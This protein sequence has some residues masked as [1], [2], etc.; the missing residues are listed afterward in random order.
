L[1]ADV[2]KLAEVGKPQREVYPFRDELQRLRTALG[3]RIRELR[4]LKG[5]RQEASSDNA[6]IHRTFAGSLE[7][8]EKNV[9]L[10]ALALIVRCFDMTLAELFAGLDAG[11]RPVPK[12]CLYRP[13]LNMQLALVQKAANIERTA[14]ALKAIASS[15][16]DGFVEKAGN[17]VGRGSARKR[18]S[19]KKSDG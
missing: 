5:W 7:R 4:K 13:W 12:S 6:H 15:P 14:W 3:L 11:E 19:L 8:G 16:A 2:L 9:S 10:H 1:D 17:R 18:A